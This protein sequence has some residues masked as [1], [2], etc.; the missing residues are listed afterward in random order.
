LAYQLQQTELPQN[1][2]VKTDRMTSAATKVAM[3]WWAARLSTPA[4]PIEWHMVEDRA[5]CMIYIRYGWDGMMPHR[6]TQG[7]T[8]MPDNQS[9]DGLATVKLMNPW[10][11]AHEIGHLIGCRH[12]RGV[13]RAH[14]IAYDERLW[15]DNDAL[16]F[17][18][19]V[20]VKASGIAVRR[21]SV[22]MRGG[23]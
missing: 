11:V 21:D 16:H 7:Y 3:D 15:I 4:R 8:Y 19:L 22:A 5:H 23:Y 2:A 12:G 20:R 6:S 9:Y 18:L 14:H 13:M 10:V 1:I 17:A